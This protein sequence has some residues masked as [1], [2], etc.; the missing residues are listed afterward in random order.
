MLGRLEDNLR[1]LERGKLD[2]PPGADLCLFLLSD[3]KLHLAAKAERTLR[4]AEFFEKYG[5]SANGKE[6]NTRYTEAIHMDHLERILG[7]RQIVQG[8]TTKILQGYV[9]VR[10]KEEGND[11]VVSHLTIKKEIGTFSSIWN[12][13]AKPLG[14]VKG[15]A[16]TRGPSTRRRSRSRRSRRGSK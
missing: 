15:D 11:G 4:L 6:A 10:A 7:G 12:L 14:M 16:A 9:N 8:I 2:V 3:G 5:D 13:W 1:L